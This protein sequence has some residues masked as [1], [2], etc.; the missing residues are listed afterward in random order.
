MDHYAVLGVQNN[1]SDAEIKKAYRKLAQQHH[2]DKNPGDKS[3]EERFKRIAEAYGVLS[4][5]AKKHAYDASTRANFSR[6]TSFD[7]FVSG[8][9]GNDFRNGARFKRTHHQAGETL[10][11]SEYLDIRIS[12]R[13]DLKEAVLGKKL[14]IEYSRKK[15]RYTSSSGNQVSFSKEDETKE[16]AINLNLRALYLALKKEGGKT[17]ARVRVAKMGN[18]DI[19]SRRNVWGEVEQMPLFGDLYVEIEIEMPSWVEIQGKNVIHAIEIPLYSILAKDEKIRIETVFDK[20]YDAEINA[21]K[22]LS[23]MRF[24]LP[25]QGI[26]GEDGKLGDYI[27]RFEVLTPNIKSLK[28]EERDK[29]LLALKDI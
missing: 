23:E 13:V 12:Q 26:L 7:D 2:P 27:V 15:I 1:A 9:G 21:P 25:E 3:A 14:E 10:P 16:I 18:E 17:V 5:P 8:F 20:K 29:L 22:T 28:K 19:Y 11:S 4:D 6:K 24:T